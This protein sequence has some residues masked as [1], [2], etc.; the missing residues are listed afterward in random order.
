[1]TRPIL[2][3]KLKEDKWGP[4]VESYFMTRK[5][6]LDKVLYSLIRTKDLGLAQELYF[7]IKEGEQTL[8][9]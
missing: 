1:V 7:R 3:E 8:A 4:K 6:A 9:I 2:L 5:Q